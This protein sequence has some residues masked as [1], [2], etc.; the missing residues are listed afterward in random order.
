MLFRSIVSADPEYTITLDQDISLEAVF[1][2]TLGK[3]LALGKAC[4]C[5]LYTSSAVPKLGLQALAHLPCRLVGKGHRSDLPVSY[6][7]LDVYKRQPPSCPLSI[8]F[9]CSPVSAL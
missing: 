9:D 7:H 5:L 8:C 2:S 4:T 1:V 6:T 3:N